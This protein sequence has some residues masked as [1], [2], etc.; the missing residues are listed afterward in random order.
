[1]I[2][3]QTIG[4]ILSKGINQETTIPPKIYR[5]QRLGQ[6]WWKT[7]K[8]WELKRKEQTA[9]KETK[10]NTQKQSMNSKWELDKVEKASSLQFL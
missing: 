6:T 3:I 10:T 1:M 8:R 7:G 5:F 4:D 2:I 9:L